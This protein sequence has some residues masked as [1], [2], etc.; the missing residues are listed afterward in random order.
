MGPGKVT[1][2]ISFEGSPE[3]SR[4]LKNELKDAS[5]SSADGKVFLVLEDEDCGALLRSKVNTALRTAETVSGVSR[6]LA[7]GKTAKDEKV[8]K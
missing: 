5:V 3:L 4:A 1:V 6:A 7:T 8:S 2:S